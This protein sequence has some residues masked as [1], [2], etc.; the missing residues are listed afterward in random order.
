MKTESS[1]FGIPV[2]TVPSVC[3]YDVPMY[4]SSSGVVLRGTCLKLLQILVFMASAIGI[5]MVASVLHGH[6]R[7]LA[8]RYVTVL[9]NLFY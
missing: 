8:S 2:L 6:V 7:A 3:L 4:S 9:F 5:S 1:G